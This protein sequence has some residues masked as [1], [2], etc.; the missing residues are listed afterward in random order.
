MYIHKKAMEYEGEIQNRKI[1][2]YTPKNV[3]S[4]LKVYHP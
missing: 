4:N 1:R 3:D 2:F